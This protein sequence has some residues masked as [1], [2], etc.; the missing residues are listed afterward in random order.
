MLI[1]IVRIEQPTLVHTTLMQLYCPL[2]FAIVVS[3]L[4]IRS[5]LPSVWLNAKPRV[6]RMRCTALTLRMAFWN[7]SILGL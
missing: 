4:R 3:Y 2:A 1:Y 7:W 6:R 5:A